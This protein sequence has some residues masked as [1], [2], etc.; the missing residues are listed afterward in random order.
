MIVY[1]EKTKTTFKLEW[2]NNML[3]K[4]WLYSRVYENNVK[5]LYFSLT[6]FG[7]SVTIQKTKR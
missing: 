1:F 2:K 3:F 7:L 4:H 5:M 6:F